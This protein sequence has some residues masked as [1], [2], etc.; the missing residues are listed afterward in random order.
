MLKTIAPARRII[1]V[2]SLA[3]LSSCGAPGDALVHSC[4]TEML[5]L[6]TRCELTVETLPASR[7]AF[8]DG[9]TKNERVALSGTFSLRKGRVTV[10]VPACENAR[11]EV[12]PDGPATIRCDPRLNRNT[13][14]FEVVASPGEGGA[15]GLSG[16]LEF[17]AR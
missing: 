2:S 6:F 11:V 17:R 3:A 4:R 1:V 15:E 8:I 16:H 5:S 14:R 9:N 10:S 13:F 12:T 7:S